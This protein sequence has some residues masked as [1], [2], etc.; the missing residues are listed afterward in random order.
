MQA[1]AKDWTKKFVAQNNS[2]YGSAIAS[3][4]GEDDARLWEVDLSLGD[5]MGLGTAGVAGLILLGPIG[6]LAI[7]TGLVKLSSSQAPPPDPGSDAAASEAAAAAQAAQEAEEA[8]A[9]QDA[10][11]PP[12][13]GE[14]PDAAPTP[15]EGSYS[16]E[17]AEEAREGR[18]TPAHLRPNDHQRQVATIEHG[19]ADS[20]PRHLT[21]VHEEE[22]L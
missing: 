15:D 19:R 9:A 20:T 18:T 22:Q 5:E 6:L 13:A 7:L 10:G 4:M 21:T 11:T 1:Q 16:A 8:Q 17:A 2:K 3:L 14:P 12:D